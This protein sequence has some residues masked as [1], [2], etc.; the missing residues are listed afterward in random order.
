[1][2]GVID[3]LSTTI[4][5]SVEKSTS[6]WPTKTFDNYERVVSDFLAVAHSRFLAF[7]PYVKESERPAWDQYA[8]VNQGWIANSY[9]EA[10]I[11]ATPQDIPVKPYG[12]NAAGSIVPTFQG[13]AMPLWQI[14]SPPNDTS[15]V[16]F[17]LLSDSLFANAFTVALEKKTAAFTDLLRSN[18][19]LSQVYAETSPESAILYPMFRDNTVV[20]S[21]LSI[22]S[23]DAFMDNLYHEHMNG[24]YVVLKNSCDQVYTYKMG[25]N[26]VDAVGQ[27][28]LHE[29]EYETKVHVAELVSPL[30]LDGDA[31]SKYCEYTLHVYPSSELE[32]EFKSETPII[33]AIAVSLLFF[34][35]S[36]GF[37]CYDEKQQEAAEEA[38]QS[39]A[40]VNSLFPTEVRK[41]LFNKE[42]ETSAPIIPMGSGNDS[43]REETID[44]AIQA[45][46]MFRLKNYLQEAEPSMIKK[47]ANED[48]AESKPIADFFPQTTVLFADIAGFTAWSSVREPSQVFTLLETIYKAF[49]TTAK[50]RKVFKVETVGDCY[51]AVTGLVSCMSF[52]D[53]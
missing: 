42:Q 34:L 17:D 39:N 23:W 26:G 36:A 11:A 29:K 46:Q 1:M 50:K 44:P 27:G 47:H 30:E 10:G 31:Q 52:S 5:A 41:R 16:N 14:S 22:I 7:S 40:I 13:P 8:V 35:A 37:Y 28:D 38:A 20:A 6:P 4:D 9:K 48:I 18:N 32:G 19:L 3:T 45:A 21:V 53:F 33:L 24:I 51:V 15:I 43:E 2:I 12:F 25:K 49:D